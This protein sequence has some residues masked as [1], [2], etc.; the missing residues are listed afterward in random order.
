MGYRFIPLC[1][2]VSVPLREGE[3][4]AMLYFQGTDATIWRLN[5]DGTGGSKVAG[6]KSGT[7]P[8]VY[9]NSIYFQG[10][11]FT[12]WQANLDGSNLIALGKNTTA[13]S[14]FVTATGVYFRGTD[15]RQG[16]GE[17]YQ[18]NNTKLWR[19][20]LD[21]TGQ[22]NLGGYTT[23]STPFVIGQ[24]VF[25]QGTD[26][27]LW[28]VLI[29]GTG[30]INLGL[31]QTSSSPFATSRYVFFR[32]TDDKLWR[33]NLDGTEGIVLG[34]GYKTSAT[35]FV[36]ETPLG[37]DGFVYF[38]GTDDKLW[39]TDLNGNNGVNLG[40]YKC[41]SSPTVDTS[42]GFIYF[43]GTDNALWRTDLDGHNGTHLGG[44]DT[45]STPFVVQPDNQ[46]QSGRFPIPYAVL[47]LV[48]APAGT[49]AGKSDPNNSLVEYSSGSTAG[50]TVS[51]TKSFKQTYGITASIGSG[52]D[53]SDSQSLGFGLSYADQSSD[54]SSLDIKKTITN[55]LKVPGPPSDGIDHSRDRIFILLSPTMNVT[56][57]PQYNMNWGL[58]FAGQ[59][60]GVVYLQMDWLQDLDLFAKVEPDVKKRC[61]A[62]GM[63]A[64]DYA[65]LLSLNPFAKG[66]APIDTNR[67][68]RT[69]INWPYEPPETDTDAVPVY[70]RNVSSAVTYT[71]Q[72]TS[73]TTW[74]LSAALGATF[75]DLLKLALGG[76]AAFEWSTTN[77]TLTTNGTAQIANLA[78][79]GPA[80]G[81]SG[82]T[83]FIVYLDTVFNTYMF[84]LSDDEPMTFSGV[85][86]DAAGQLLANTEVKLTVGSKAYYTYTNARGVYKFYNTP[87]G[88]GQVSVVEKIARLIDGLH[89]GSI[90]KKL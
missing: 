18:G 65:Q 34:G 66:P 2:Q 56:I 47:L 52:K 60:G 69:D 46:P 8:V 51:I 74:S 73:Q 17:T 64:G 83:Q 59:N 33:A 24:Y 53:G 84:V 1:R 50:T 72:S 71:D 49:N 26:N 13:D 57:D 55:D 82:P 28:R 36:T 89:E 35:P 22:V 32:G 43:Q 4:E 76:T 5:Q 62:A 6:L 68:Q 79:G 67:Y 90:T 23:Q 61:D 21:G 85:L 39:R 75:P 20:G 38:R 12:L 10:T 11:D 19:I 54:T 70:T 40:G 41:A 3:N 37:A 88:E 78:F 44:F 45:A 16:R 87:K 7:R 14:P 42:Q 80:A 48:Y 25:F 77:S 31:F 81:Y 86:K 58:D 29:D 27:K 15:T 9:G 63:T 30:G